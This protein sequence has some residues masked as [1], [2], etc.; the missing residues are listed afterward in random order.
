MA[1]ANRIYR[2]HKYG[3]PEV[4]RLETLPVQNPGAGE[5]RV[6]VQAMSLNRADL[7]WMAN[8]YVET[9]TLPSRVGYEISGVVEAVGA[10]VIEFSIGDRVSSIPAFSISHYANF[11]E[12]TIL[13]TKGLMK[14]PDNFT[15]AQ[16]AGFAFAY[17]TG[18]F[19]RLLPRVNP[20]R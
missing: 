6:K 14:T 9:P 1:T 17:F 3:N 11:G 15:P 16:G 4:L 8:A 12:T 19:A 20:E 5:V 10:D 7:L 2:F 13:P 18:Y